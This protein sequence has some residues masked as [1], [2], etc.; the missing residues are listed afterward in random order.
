M[1]DQETMT[2]SRRRPQEILRGL[3]RTIRR[4]PERLLHPFR[5]RRALSALRG[6]E[7]CTPLLFVCHGNICRSPFAAG[8][9]LERLARMPG[10][11][12]AVEVDSAG[13]IEPDR[14][15]PSKAQASARSRGVDLSTHRSRLLTSDGVGMAAIVFVM[16]ELQQRA[17]CRR[18]RRSEEDVII[19]GD[20]DPDPIERRTIR[21]PV[22]QSREVFDGSYARIERCIDVLTGTLARAL[23]VDLEAGG[24]GR[25]PAGRQNHG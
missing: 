12:L 2:E 20:L 6:R 19:L 5:H 23:P 14:P 13:F 7:A 25:A 21:D 16:D 4:M 15:S 9:L 3:A 17:I 18:F 1:R 24:P 22:E 8:L 11:G 10:G